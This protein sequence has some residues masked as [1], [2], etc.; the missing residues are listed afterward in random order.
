MPVPPRFPV[1]CKQIKNFRKNVTTTKKQKK[2]RMR[3]SLDEL[4][5]TGAS[6]AEKE[7][8]H[9]VPPGPRAFQCRL[10]PWNP[11][12]QPSS[13]TASRSGLSKGNSSASLDATQS[14]VGVIDF[15]IRDQLLTAGN[16]IYCLIWGGGCTLAPLK[17]GYQ[18]FPKMQQQCQAP[19]GLITT[20]PRLSKYSISKMHQLKSLRGI[21]SL[22]GLPCRHQPPFPR[23]RTLVARHR[24]SDKWALLLWVDATVWPLQQ[25]LSPEQQ[26]R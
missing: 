3:G 11:N 23:S 9:P 1:H 17:L 25:R 18:F 10:L 15:S 21:S 20:F 14:T 5:W 13:T 22:P 26:S 4:G 16:T 19:S 24:P 12:P 2:P 7:G 6:L 8:N